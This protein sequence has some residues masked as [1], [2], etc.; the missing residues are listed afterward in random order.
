MSCFRRSSFVFGL[1][2]RMEIDSYSAAR[3]YIDSFNDPA[4]QPAASNAEAAR[5]VSRMQALLTATGDPQRGM[6]CV[7]VAGTKGKGSTCA[8]IERIV[9]AGGY[10]TGLWSSPHLNSYRERIQVDRTLIS[11]DALTAIVRA[12][13]PALDSF[14][15]QMYGRPSWFD[16]GFLCALH[17]F[18]QQQIELAVL[19]VGVGGRY[20][21]VN[22]I[23][24]LVSVI[25]AISY[26]H[27]KILG[28]TLAE[29]AWNKAGIIKPA[30]PAI[31]VPQQ[32]AA[33][34]TLRCEARS[35]ETV[36][37]VAHR[38]AIAGKGGRLPYPVAPEPTLLRGPFQQQ[39]ARL[40][41]GAAMLLRQHGYHLSDTALAEGLAEASW[42]GRL[43]IVGRQPLMVLDGAHNGD[44]AHKLAEAL[45]AEFTFERLVGHVTGQRYRGD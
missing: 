45:Q 43:E 13:K 2:N 22:A 9:R 24:P 12:L 35:V 15:T 31:T 25:S 41:L 4:R 21:S 17:Y 8:M 7:I 39:N 36:L 18:A 20:D 11:P 5:N 27:M 10:R 33:A 34:A 3:A 42:P 19:E 30:V 1:R 44:S 40:A 6:N 38:E 29:I 23:T 32:P 26:D 28:N 14:D 16:V 37:W